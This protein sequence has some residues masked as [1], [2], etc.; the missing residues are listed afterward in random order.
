LGVLR[1]PGFD[2]QMIHSGNGSYPTGMTDCKPLNAV[3]NEGLSTFS[4]VLIIDLVFA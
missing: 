2:P 1:K 3:V 4:G